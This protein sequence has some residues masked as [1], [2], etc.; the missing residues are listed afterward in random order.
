MRGTKRGPGRT[1]L[2]KQRWCFT[3]QPVNGGKNETKEEKLE[4]KGMIK[5]LENSYLNNKTAMLP[6]DQKI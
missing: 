4:V 6:S 5:T 3:W 1:E 2:E